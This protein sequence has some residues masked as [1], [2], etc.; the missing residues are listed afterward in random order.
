MSKI[1]AFDIDG[2]FLNSKHEVQQSHI[3][4]CLKAKE[5]GHEVVLCSGRPY[6]DMIPVINQV[7]EGMFRYLICNN[8]A[9]IVDLTTMNRIMPNV[10]PTSILELFEEI[11]KKYKFGFAVHTLS[12]INRGVFWEMNDEHPEWF[13]KNSQDTHE[14]IEN[15]KEWEFC[16]EVAQNEK[17]SQL[18]F[19]GD[20]EEIKKAL[21]EFDK[22][23][24]EINI[25]IAGEIYLDINPINVS[26]LTGIEILAKELNTTSESFVVFGDSGND[27]Q[28]LKGAGLGIAMGNSTQEAK[29]SADIIIGNNNTSALA[30]KVIELI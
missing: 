25:H 29:D 15:F 24:F 3:D 23:D 5:N 9:Y 10:V 11:G 1:F 6:F 21:K 4:A 2:T 12:S 14:R 26:K 20:K 30:D 18:S 28:M 22:Y 19:I 7:P 8:G 27:I 17:V 16:K 13:A